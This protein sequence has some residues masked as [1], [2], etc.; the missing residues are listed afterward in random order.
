MN[1]RNILKSDFLFTN[2]NFLIGAGSVLNIKG[3]YFTFNRSET[4]EKADELAIL[5]DW[6]NTGNDLEIAIKNK[7]K[8]DI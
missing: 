6:Q 2:S 3:N 5:S 1:E 4:P 7:N 8:I